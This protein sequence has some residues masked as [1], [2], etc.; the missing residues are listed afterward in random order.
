[1]QVS[2]HFGQQTQLFLAGIHILAIT[3][4]EV[5]GKKGG[6]RGKK[7]A[8]KGEKERKEGNRRTKR[9]RFPIL[10]LSAKNGEEFQQFTIE[11]FLDGFLV[12]ENINWVN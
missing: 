1:M 5:R 12:N 9:E 11:I 7:E 4:V 8:K 2:K 10:I 3:G 6:K